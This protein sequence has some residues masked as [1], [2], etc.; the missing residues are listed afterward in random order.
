MA[1]LTY[2]HS[3][4]G[5][6]SPPDS[7]SGSPLLPLGASSSEKGKFSPCRFVDPR[8][9]H[10]SAEFPEPSMGFEPKER[11][12]HS[13]EDV[14]GGGEVRL[15]AA[16]DSAEQSSD[17]SDE[18]EG[19]APP[20]GYS[21]DGEDSSDREE[22]ERVVLDPKNLLA[23]SSDVEDESRNVDD[24]MDPKGGSSDEE[25]E[26]KI[27][28]DSTDP[29]VEPSDSEEE[30]LG[31][32][33]DAEEEPAIDDDSVDPL[34]EPSDTE[35]EPKM[36]DDSMDP[37]VEYSDAEEEPAGVDN[38]NEMLADSSEDEEDHPADSSDNEDDRPSSPTTV[39]ESP[40][41]V[42]G[43]LEGGESLSAAKV[44]SIKVSPISLG[45]GNEDQEMV[46]VELS[47]QLSDKMAVD[48]G[49]NT[50]DLSENEDMDEGKVTADS[51]QLRRSSRL[52]P[53]K[54]M[55]TALAVVK[56]AITRKPNPRRKKPSAQKNGV[57]QL[58]RVQI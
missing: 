8:D 21:S 41:H 32:Q 1:I 3:I 16:V 34:V 43:I 9:L 12:S 52:A 29:L 54:K 35:E 14:E 58:V 38:S 17:S 33:S 18:E 28:N 5:L 51:V 48:E 6:A 27:A 37:L 36:V 46:D 50:S 11:S 15:A 42:S 19:D 22:G 30:Q 7:Y 4:G 13:L 20:V 26:P 56:P 55:P 2:F 57:F 53:L 23:K 45:D 10:D 40:K 31:E 49:G 24:S 25:E 39:V 44:L 47:K